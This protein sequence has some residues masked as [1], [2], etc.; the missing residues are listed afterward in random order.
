MFCGDLDVSRTVAGRVEPHQYV[1]HGALALTATTSQIVAL[2]LFPVTKVR[3]YIAPTADSWRRVTR[4]LDEK[5]GACGFILDRIDVVAKLQ[6]LLSRG[7]R[8]RLPTEKIGA[9]AVPIVIDPTVQMG[10]RAVALGVKLARL[11]IT[12]DALWL[13][14]DVWV[15]PSGDDPAHRRQQAKG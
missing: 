12:P 5:S 15:L 1:L 10:D 3:L 8:V 6:R 4:V 2:P 13:G 14:G 11:V 9:V 7:I